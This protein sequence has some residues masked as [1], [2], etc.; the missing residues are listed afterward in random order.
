MRTTVKKQG[1]YVKVIADGHDPVENIKVSKQKEKKYMVRINLSGLHNRV[2]VL[3]KDKNNDWYTKCGNFGSDEDYDG[4][5]SKVFDTEQE[6]KLFL[7]GAK[8]FRDFM[9]QF[10]RK[11]S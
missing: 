6:A 9:E 5:V 7:S 1:S 10:F 4:C 3:F 2:Y 8:F 11:E